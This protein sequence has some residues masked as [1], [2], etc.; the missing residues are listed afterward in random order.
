MFNKNDKNYTWNSF[1]LRLSAE[2]NQ[3]TDTA[4][5]KLRLALQYLKNFDIRLI[6]YRLKRNSSFS[7]S[8]HADQPKLICLF[9]NLQ[10][11]TALS[12]FSFAYFAETI[13]SYCIGN[14]TCLRK[15]VRFFPA[16]IFKIEFYN[17]NN[18]LWKIT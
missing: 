10:T 5:V 4:L 7:L 14:E 17:I 18:F 1:L 6:N 15:D 11:S 9:H 12:K 8:F 3:V 16:P 13:I 2:P